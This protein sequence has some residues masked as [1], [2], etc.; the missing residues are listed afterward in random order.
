MSN[1]N[2]NYNENTVNKEI[3]TKVK[4]LEHYN[5]FESWPVKLDFLPNQ[6]LITTETLFQVRAWDRLTPQ[7]VKNVAGCLIETRTA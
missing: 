7:N 2:R 6:W 3:S 4:E 5:C 1:Y